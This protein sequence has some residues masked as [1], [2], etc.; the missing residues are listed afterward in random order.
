MSA[1]KVTNIIDEKEILSTEDKEC[2]QSLLHA[3]KSIYLSLM[4]KDLDSY[5]LKVTLRD[6]RD[7]NT[8]IS[9]DFTTENLVDTIKE[10]VSDDNIEKYKRYLSLLENKEE[11]DVEIR[12]AKIITDRIKTALEY[13]DFNVEVNIEN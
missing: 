1:Y 8:L 9:L 5:T 2:L 12:R 6:K 7:D 13:S 10:M 3:S 11:L 4:V